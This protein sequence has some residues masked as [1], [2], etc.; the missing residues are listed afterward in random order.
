MGI[1][2][3]WSEAAFEAAYGLFW[4]RRRISIKLR[5]PAPREP[6]LRRSSNRAEDEAPLS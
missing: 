2:T 1:P 3:R 6:N 4:A 5:S